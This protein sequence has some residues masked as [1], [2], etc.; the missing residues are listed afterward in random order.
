MLP[1]LLQI[2]LSLTWMVALNRDTSGYK[3]QE[4]ADAVAQAGF[5]KPVTRAA[6]ALR[7]VLVTYQS[8]HITPDKA[9]LLHSLSD[10][11]ELATSH[12]SMCVDRLADE[13]YF[14]VPAWELGSG[15]SSNFVGGAFESDASEVA[16]TVREQR[17]VCGR[18]RRQRQRGRGHARQQAELVSMR[19][20]APTMQVSE[21]LAK[22][23]A[24]AKE[25][26]QARSTIRR[27]Q[28]QV[29]CVAREADIGA[30]MARHNHE[31]ELSMAESRGQM[32]RADADYFSCC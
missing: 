13:V 15:A 2:H 26:A 27:L 21:L 9:T 29:E 30:G 31:I 11:L 4:V 23:S 1:Y 19:A 24:L 10:V 12:A 7:A 6:A 22:S 20:T 5:D 14:S 25:L 18:R 17:R 32:A 16:A 28:D 8:S 3:R